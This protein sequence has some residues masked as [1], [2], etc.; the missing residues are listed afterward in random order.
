MR[1][2]P[3]A[4]ETG[5]FTALSLT[6]PTGQQQTYVGSAGLPSVGLLTTRKL[7]L[8]QLGEARCWRGMPSWRSNGLLALFLPPSSQRLA[9]QV[10]R[11]MVDS[12]HPMDLGVAADCLGNLL[13]EIL[14][15]CQE[16]ELRRC[17]TYGIK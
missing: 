5:H 7:A 9:F 14:R 6:S 4:E 11:I 1:P 2:S 15:L 12:L 8:R 3:K 10:K 13:L 16:L 17:P